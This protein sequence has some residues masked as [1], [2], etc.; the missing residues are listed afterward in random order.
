M[1]IFLVLMVVLTG[2]DCLYATGYRH[3][4][5]SRAARLNRTDT[6]IGFTRT[7]IVRD[8]ETLVGIA[9]KYGLG[10]NEISILYPTVD[11]WTPRTGINLS[12]PQLWIVPPSAYHEIVINIPEMRLYRFFPDISMVKTYPVGIGTLDAPT[13]QGSYR[14]AECKI[15]PIWLIP[16]SRRTKYRTVCIRAGLRNPLGRYWIG[17]SN[18][19]YG[20]HGTNFPW[21]V[22]RLVS[23]GCIRL[24]PEHISQLFQEVSIGTRVEIIYEPVKLGFKNRQIYMEVH[25]DSYRKIKNMAAHIHTLLHSHDVETYVSMEKLKT[26]LFKKDGVPTL[27]GTLPETYGWT[28]IVNS[29]DRS[30]MKELFKTPERR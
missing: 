6:V 4:V 22:G 17:L 18:R 9:R 15:D 14:I 8:H 25:P 16:A 28:G 12:I 1:A 24:Y 10:F 5:A 27:I 19:K 2:T 23:N 7:H 13:P 20:I 26:V 11:P 3:T 30:S 21:S 29:E